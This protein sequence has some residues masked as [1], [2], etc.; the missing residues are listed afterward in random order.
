MRTSRQVGAS[1]GVAV[2]GSILAASLDRP[3]RGRF[4]PAR[5][6]DRLL[7]ACGAA[8]LFLS[9]ITVGHW[10]LN[11]ASRTAARHD[12]TEPMTPVMTG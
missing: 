2:T 8:V 1:L 3:L 9:P 11:T 10:A 4:M 6:A 12:A 7:S 5:R